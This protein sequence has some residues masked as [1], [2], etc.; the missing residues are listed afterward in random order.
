LPPDATP[1]VP[2]A[3]VLRL[4]RAHCHPDAHMA[5]FLAL[6]LRASNPPDPEMVRFKAEL[7]DLLSGGVDRLSD[8]ALCKAAQYDEDDDDKTFL[9]R[10]WHDLYGSE[11]V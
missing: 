8:G 7:R 9:V 6:V 1:D 2:Y 4:V 5:G 10:L 3:T 11:P